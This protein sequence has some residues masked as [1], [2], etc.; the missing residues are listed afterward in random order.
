M[1]A[2]CVGPLPGIIAWGTF[3][4]IALG[5]CVLLFIVGSS[6]SQRR[7]RA[8]QGLDQGQELKRMQREWREA[9]QLAA[10]EQAN[11]ADYFSP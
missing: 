10:N 9:N 3:A 7:A 2:D 1:F 6:A 11:P 8:Q 5:G 4:G